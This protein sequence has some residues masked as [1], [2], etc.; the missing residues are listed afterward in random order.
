MYIYQVYTHERLQKTALIFDFLKRE[1]LVPT[2]SAKEGLV[3]S[4]YSSWILLIAFMYFAS[5]YFN[6]VLMRCGSKSNL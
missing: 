6:T 4:F 3:G 5:D 2:L 1:L